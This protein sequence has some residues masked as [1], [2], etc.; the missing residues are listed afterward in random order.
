M[1]QCVKRFGC[2]PGSTTRSPM[3]A[4]LVAPPRRLTPL[5]SHPCNRPSRRNTPANRAKFSP[6]HSLALFDLN[7]KESTP[8]RAN[9]RPRP[10]HP[11][12]SFQQELTISAPLTPLES[13]S[14]TISQPKPFRITFLRKNRGGG[15]HYV[16]LASQ[17]GTTPLPGNTVCRAAH[18]S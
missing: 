4:R 16:K 11:S 2:Q 17:N 12:T 9:T 1:L 3:N 8:Y 7:R 5:G 13:H 6:P 10:R 18:I 14:C 15:G